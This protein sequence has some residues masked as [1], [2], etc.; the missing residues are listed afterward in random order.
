VSHDHR[1]VPFVDAVYNLE[2]GRLADP[3]STREPRDT[4]A[5]H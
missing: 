3:E 2:D 4:A 1:I 5:T